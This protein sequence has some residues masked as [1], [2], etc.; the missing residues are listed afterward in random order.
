MTFD[1]RNQYLNGRAVP[2]LKTS[3]LL[4]YD[5]LS[6]RTHRQRWAGWR[7][8]HQ[9]RRNHPLPAVSDRPILFPP[10]PLIL[11]RLLPRGPL[12][13][14]L[15]P[16]PRVVARSSPIR[17]YSLPPPSPPPPRHPSRAK[18]KTSVEVVGHRSR[19]RGRRHH[20]CRRRIR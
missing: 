16:P 18:L 11:R 10:R 17:S 8:R 4:L 19:P 7:T 9:F 6:T 3:T 15:L 5:Y 14:V 1:S 20:R 2:D 12:S 13:S